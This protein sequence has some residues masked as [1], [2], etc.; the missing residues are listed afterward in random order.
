MRSLGAKIGLGAIGVFLV[1]LV[2]VSTARETTQAVAQAVRQHLHNS[3][4]TQTVQNPGVV[5][6]LP[7]RL[8]GERIGTVTNLDLRRT[9]RGDPLEVRATVRLTAD[10]GAGRLAGCDV[11]PVEADHFELEDG[12]RCATSDDRN[13]VAVGTIRFEP[14]GLT[15][16]LKVAPEALEEMSEGSSFHATADLSGQVHV[17]GRGDEGG[18][19]D[20]HADHGQ[21]SIA[22][23]DDAGRSLLQLFADTTGA[24][25]H[26]RDRNGKNVMRLQADRHGVSFTVDKPD[27]N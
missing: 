19:F 9:K 27:S 21:A 20:L 25:L 6:D 14:A 10:D 18:G 2:I 12:F 1:G 24:F 3:I 4:S 7:F 8:D 23:T 13:L 17:R 26:I 22:A 11:V 5:R 16:M 15:R